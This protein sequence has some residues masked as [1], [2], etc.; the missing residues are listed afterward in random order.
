MVVDFVFKRTPAYRVATLSRTGGWN[1]KKLRDQFRT[2]AAWARKNHLRIGRWIFYE[3]NERTF[4]AALEVKG[5][6]KGEGRIRLRTLPAATVASVTFNPDEIEPEVIYHG[7]MDWLRWRKRAKEIQ[8]V[9]MAREVYTG[10][11]WSG[12]KIWARTDVQFVVKR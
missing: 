11:P 8:S 10:D 3:P 9:G 5:R 7:L 2:L 1:E 4:V 12:P 6:A